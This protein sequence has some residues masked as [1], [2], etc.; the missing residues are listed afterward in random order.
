MKVD[1]RGAH[2]DAR[3]GGRVGERPLVAPKETTVRVPPDR[4]VAPQLAEAAG[5][6]LGHAGKFVVDGQDF[7]AQGVGLYERRDEKLGE[8]VER[9]A[10]RGG[11]AVEVVDRVF[12]LGIRV[13]HAAVAGEV[14]VVAKR[15]VERRGVVG[16]GA[17]EHADLPPPPRLFSHSFSS[18]Y[19]AEPMKSM[20][21]R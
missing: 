8:P 11:A 13:G 2:V 3:R 15:G 19:L 10:E 5:I 7:A 16:R 4:R 6:G 18:G 20:C 21:S 9:A 1:D 17:R 14:G 12:E